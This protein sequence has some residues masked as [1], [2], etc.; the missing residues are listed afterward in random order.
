VLK[1]NAAQSRRVGL[2][3]RGCVALLALTGWGASVAQPVLEK[4][5]DVD[6]WVA[7]LASDDW[8]LRRQATDGLIALGED[9]L[10]RLVQLVE[11][12]TDNEVRARAQAAIR[13][14]E[15]DRLTG[16]TLLTLRLSNVSAA[17][18]FAAVARQARAPL[19]VDPP[20]LLRKITKP[21]S[22]TVERRPF[23]QVMQ[24]LSAQ[25]DVE[26]T[27]I[28]RHNRELGLG[29]TRGG[30]DWMDK[31]IV[32]AGPLLIRA[33]RLTR[34]ST[35]SLKPP[36]DASEEFAISLTVF[37]EPKLKV[38]DFSQTVRLDEAT[39][40]KGN[41]LLPPQT[42]TAF[43]RTWTSSGTSGTG[44]PAVGMSGRHSTTPRARGRGSNGCAVRPRCSWRRDRPC[45]TCRWRP[46]A[47]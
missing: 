10:P 1:P 38:L 22:L 18:A 23:W 30:T 6:R 14:I 44:I 36:R 12:T 37:A 17:E 43:P 3:I 8:K 5:S 24:S 31:P 11:T 9:A 41:S 27:G 2:A 32:L 28:T 19:A 29:V 15:D 39:D 40:D 46:R 33:D 26:V 7:Q 47:T 34:V 13:Q 25:T 21:V 42:R 16:M 4:R 35:I 45:S 20:D